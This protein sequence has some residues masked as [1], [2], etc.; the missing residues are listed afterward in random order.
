M[1]IHVRLPQTL[2]ASIHA[3]LS[4]PHPFAAER[5]GFLFC[6]SAALSGEGLLLLG[7]K[8]HVVD[9]RDY[10]DDR[11]VGACIGPGAFRDVLQQVYRAP[12]SIL[13]IH[14]HDHSGRPQFSRT[15]VKSMYEFVPGFFNACRS[16]PH[17]A[18][19]LSH[20]SAEGRI[21]LHSGSAG[22]TIGRYE[23]IGTP[24]Q[25]WSQS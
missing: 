4:R 2:L 13:H 5:V 6:G 10:I 22:H 19:V 8:W 14:R 11:S 1:K 17:G 24:M 20:D 7:Q 3:D 21:W 23:L 9:D 25:R 18:V 16:H 15:D 12:A